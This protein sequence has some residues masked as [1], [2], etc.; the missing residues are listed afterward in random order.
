SARRFRLGM[1]HRARRCFGHLPAYILLFAEHAWSSD[2]PG[3][4]HPPPAQ[5]RSH[6]PPL[7]EGEYAVDFSAGR[8]DVDARLNELELADDVVVV[9]DRYRLTADR[10]RLRRSERGIVVDG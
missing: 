5:A 8:V 3:P 7:D 2:A 6:S 1:A 10:L 4:R 9:V